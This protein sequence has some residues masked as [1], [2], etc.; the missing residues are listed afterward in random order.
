MSVWKWVCIVQFTVQPVHTVQCKVWSL[1]C[2][3]HCKCAV[4]SIVY[5]LKRTVCS[6]VQLS[7]CRVWRVCRDCL[8]LFP[9]IIPSRLIS[10]ELPRSLVQCLLQSVAKFSLVHSLGSFTAQCII[11]FLTM[12]YWD[13]TLQYECVQLTVQ[14][15]FTLQCKVWSFLWI[16]HFKMCR[17]QYSLQCEADSLLCCA[18]QWL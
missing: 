14:H 13:Q 15:L 7:D 18:P 5:S 1:L 16:V 9:A 11:S 6:A 2:I 17:V 10:A 3:V 8:P 12:G 4:F